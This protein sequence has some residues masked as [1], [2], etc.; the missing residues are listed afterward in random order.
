MKK[1]NKIWLWL[2][3]ALLLLYFLSAFV[4]RCSRE[5]TDFYDVMIVTGSREETPLEKLDAW[6]ADSL[7][8]RFWRYM[9]TPEAQ[10]QA[11]KEAMESYEMENGITE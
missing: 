10:R 4:T 3:C 11:E 9:A 8:Y 7:P 6:L 2:L 1:R 5:Q